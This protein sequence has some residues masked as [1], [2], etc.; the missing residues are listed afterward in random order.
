MTENLFCDSS[1][2]RKGQEICLFSEMSGM[3]VC[4]TISAIHW[5]LGFVLYV[6]CVTSC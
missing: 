1:F 5:V 6:L 3:A 4:L 2:P